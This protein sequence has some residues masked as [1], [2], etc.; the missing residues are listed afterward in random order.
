MKN[1]LTLLLLTL[2]VFFT[3]VLKI[4]GSIITEL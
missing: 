2:I 3:R 4:I 1:L